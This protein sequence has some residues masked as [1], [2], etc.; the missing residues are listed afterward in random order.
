MVDLSSN[1][2][3]RDK[4]L[5][6]TLIEALKYKNDAPYIAFIDMTQPSY[7]KRFFLY[8]LDSKEVVREH[9]VSHGVGSAKPSDKAYA[10]SFS[11]VNMSKKSSLGMMR[12]GKVYYGKHGRS[13]KL[14]GLEKGVNDNV[15]RRSIVIHS[16][17]YVA[18]RYIKNNNRVGCSWGC[19]ALD[20][21]I[22]NT[23]IDLIKEGG[24]L[25]IYYE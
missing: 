24:L 21:A 3:S 17:S 8:S 14:E 6:K 1:K 13:L 2:Q 9:H 20:P 4:A 7:R 12:T 5:K 10:V 23:I 15:Y 18:D 25:Y 16:A 22:C 19:P 11:N